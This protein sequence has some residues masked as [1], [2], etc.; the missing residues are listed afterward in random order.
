MPQQRHCWRP[1]LLIPVRRRFKL[2]P[3]RLL[4]AYSVSAL[5]QDVGPQRLQLAMGCGQML[6]CPASKGFPLPGVSGIRHKRASN[7][8]PCQIRS[9]RC[10]CRHWRKVR[11]RRITSPFLI[12]HSYLNGYGL[13][14]TFSW[15]KCAISPCYKTSGVLLLPHSLL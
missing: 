1:G 10:R 3:Q 7:A 12:T 11:Q 5:M 4:N 14:C 9:I 2:L 15:I 8:Q 6:R 13:Y